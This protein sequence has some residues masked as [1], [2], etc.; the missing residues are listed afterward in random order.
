MV[1]SPSPIVYPVIR[2]SW[3]D[4]D[5]EDVGV[6]DVSGVPLFCGDT[7]ILS[8]VSIEAEQTIGARP[9]RRNNNV[10]DFVTR[11]AMVCDRT[12]AGLILC[13]LFMQTW[14]EDDLE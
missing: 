1:S 7:R 8:P 11:I 4:D 13:A 5:C 2:A 3:V 10:L 6:V 12:M 9:C 14:K